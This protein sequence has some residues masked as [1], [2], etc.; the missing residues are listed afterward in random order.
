MLFGK[1]EMYGRHGANSTSW[2]EQPLGDGGACCFE[3]ANRRAEKLSNMRISMPELSRVPLSINRR[4]GRERKR[5]SYFVPLSKQT[6]EL[7]DGGGYKAERESGVLNYQKRPH[8][9]N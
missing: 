9:P 6:T 7:Q 5:D 8:I 3:A 4:R 1:E 2:S